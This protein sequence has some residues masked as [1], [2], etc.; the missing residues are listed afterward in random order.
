MISWHRPLQ[1][2]KSRKVLTVLLQSFSRKFSPLLKRSLSHC[3]TK[4]SG[5]FSKWGDSCFA[6]WFVL[7]RL[8]FSACIVNNSLWITQVSIYQIQNSCYYYM[9]PTAALSSLIANVPW[10]LTN[11]Q[12]SW[13]VFHVA[14]CFSLALGMPSPYIDKQTNGRTDRRTLKNILSSLLRGR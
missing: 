7:R 6:Y 4:T 13:S 5:L 1:C 3:F 11:T 9:P 8:I 10:S 12:R 14:W 2:H